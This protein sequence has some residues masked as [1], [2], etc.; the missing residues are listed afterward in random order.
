MKKIIHIVPHNVETPVKGYI[1]TLCGETTPV[2]RSTGRITSSN[3]SECIDRYMAIFVDPPEDPAA[4]EEDEHDSTDIN[5]ELSELDRMISSNPTCNTH[6][7]A[8][9]ISSIEIMRA[10]L[11][12]EQ[13]QGFYL[14]NAIK[15]TLRAN[16]KGQFAS[17]V[18][19]A[20]D[21][22]SWLAETLGED[23]E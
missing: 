20:L 10:K 1:K 15:Y 22:I 16:H 8:G 4:E 14:G 23:N 3:C 11:T 9:G 2:A 17:D 5:E 12:P 21:Y 19:K 7:D 6:Y 18:R 13:L